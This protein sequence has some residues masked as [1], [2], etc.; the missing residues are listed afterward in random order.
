MAQNRG[1]QRYEPIAQIGAGAFG[2]V[3]LAH[4]GAGALVAVKATKAPDDPL[5]LRLAQREARALRQCD[6]PCII[7]LLDCFRSPSGRAYLVRGYVNGCA[8]TLLESCPRGLS[9]VTLKLLAWQMCLALSHMHTGQTQLLHRDIKPSNILVNAEGVAKLCDFGLARALPLATSASAASGS[10][11]PDASVGSAS[12]GSRSGSG[13]GSGGGGSGSGRY[14]AGAQRPAQQPQQQLLSSYVVTR[15][16]RPPEILLSQ[17][18]GP[19]ADIFSLGATIAELAVGIP[20]FPGA[21]TPDQLN[22]LCRCFGPLPPHMT[23]AL[24]AMAARSATPA[25]AAELSVV[26][27]QR[28]R[29]LKQRLYGCCDGTGGYTTR[30]IGAGGAAPGAAAAPLPRRSARAEPDA[31]LL[32]F[33][34]ACME[35]D[36]AMRRTADQLLDL[37]YFDD[38]PQ[39]VAASGS[40]ALYELLTMEVGKRS[41][42]AAAAARAAGAAEVQED[43]AVATVCVSHFRQRVAPRTAAEGPETLH[44]GVTRRLRAAGLD[45]QQQQQQQQQS[46]AA[47]GH[48]AGIVA[49]GGSGLITKLGV[50]KGAHTPSATPT[51]EG[52]PTPQATTPMSGMSAVSVATSVLSFLPSPPQPPPLHHPPQEQEISFGDGVAPPQPHRHHHHHHHDH[53][54]HPHANQQTQAPGQHQHVLDTQPSSSCLNGASTDGPLACAQQQQ[55]QQ[56]PFMPHTLPAGAAAAVTMSQQQRS[57]PTAAGVA[58]AAIGPQQLDRAQSGP[59]SDCGLSTAPNGSTIAGTTVGAELETSAFGS[60]STSGFVAFSSATGSGRTAAPVR[61]LCTSEGAA[62]KGSAGAGV[63]YNQQALQLQPPSPQPQSGV[64]FMPQP[65]AA[66]GLSNVPAPGPA[67]AVGGNLAAAAPDV[68]SSP[69]AASAPNPTI[70]WEQLYTEHLQQKK[71]QLQPQLQ[72][73]PF[74]QH[75]PAA[76]PGFGAAAS[77]RVGAELPAAPAA[78][79]VSAPLYVSCQPPGMVAR[80]PSVPESTTSPAAAALLQ[81]LNAVMGAA[82]A[83]QATKQQSESSFKEEISFGED[84]AV[85]GVPPAATRSNTAGGSSSSAGGSRDTR[86]ASAA[87]SPLSQ[88]SSRAAHAAGNVQQTAAAAAATEAAVG[89]AEGESSPPRAACTGAT[90]TAAATAAAETAA[91]CQQQLP[92]PQQLVVPPGVDRPWPAGG[93]GDPGGG[94]P[95]PEAAPATAAPASGHEPKNWQAAVLET[96]L[97]GVP[98]DVA[99]L[100]STGGDATGGWPEAACPGSSL[101]SGGAANDDAGECTAC[102]RTC[103]NA[104]PGPAVAATTV[105]GSAVEAAAAPECAGGFSRL[106]ELELLG[107]NAGEQEGQGGHGKQGVVRVWPT[108]NVSG[109]SVCGGA[110]LSSTTASRSSSN[111]SSSSDSSRYGGSGGSGGSGSVT[112]TTPHVCTS[113]A[114]FAAA[115]AAVDLES[116]SA[117]GAGAAAAPHA[118]AAAVSSCAIS[119]SNGGSFSTLRRPPAECFL[120][121]SRTA[122]P[123]ILRLLELAPA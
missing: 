74:P 115:A 53:H 86:A 77:L 92:P 103:G 122:A 31:R 87:R 19:P 91:P 52:G 75:A 105:A 44:D 4:N 29:T 5:S 70:N 35:L 27:T 49:G 97:L 67:A 59:P 41:A 46:A 18:Y 34:Q 113:V 6:H 20:L 2:T 56:Q 76:S 118:Q 10:G 64:A 58:A 99:G 21:T 121:G 107:P 30:G 48:G 81:Q 89:A 11:S 23:A 80:L 12:S 32:E 66:G 39:L 78:A 117:A 93:T 88:A 16:Y 116:A 9:P 8:S 26:G 72:L 71:N 3:A 95:Q 13:V 50:G 62:L 83:A 57:P 45:D 111:S 102:D 36:P 100:I 112:G 17:T 14:V 7:K 85:A 43:A 96:M 1:A 94:T 63:S 24:A 79:A 38:V 120:R 68:G 73:Q 98:V 40:P 28:G 37:P 110:G 101:R 42:A 54:H 109:G 106:D 33:L 90:T 22:R 61:A 104:G 84:A 82:A 55:L 108:G 25:V 123:R 47:A 114:A 69:H 65:A 15:W 51:P 60:S 119:G